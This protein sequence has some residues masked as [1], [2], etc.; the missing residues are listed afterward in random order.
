MKKGHESEEI[1][2]LALVVN[3]SSLFSYDYEFSANTLRSVEIL[4]SAYTK[5]GHRKTLT[6]ESNDILIGFLTDQ[7]KAR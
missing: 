2:Y 4:L 5:R 3:G 7:G 1:D 6:I